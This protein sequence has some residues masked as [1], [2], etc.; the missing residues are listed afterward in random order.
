MWRVKFWWCRHFHRGCHE[1]NGELAKLL[2][3]RDRER[4]ISDVILY[5]CPKCNWGWSP[6]DVGA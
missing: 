3:M 4:D 6:K 5:Y 1:F 2:V